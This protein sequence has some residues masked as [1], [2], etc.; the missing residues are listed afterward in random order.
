MFLQVVISNE[1]KHKLSK[2]SNDDEVKQT[3]AKLLKTLVKVNEE[4]MVAMEKMTRLQDY[5]LTKNKLKNED[6]I[7]DSMEEEDNRVLFDF[8]VSSI[9]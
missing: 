9:N 8:A 7:Y 4:R 3:F 2:G 5:M 6:D 1:G